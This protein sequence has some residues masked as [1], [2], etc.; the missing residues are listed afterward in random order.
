MSWFNH[1]DVTPDMG[2]R[3]S[4]NAVLDANVRLGDGLVY[5]SNYREVESWELAC[6]KPVILYLGNSTGGYTYQL[7][8][9]VTRDEMTQLVD[10]IECLTEYA[11]LNDT[12]YSAMEYALCEQQLEEIA[13]EREVDSF[14]LISAYFDANYFPETDGMGTSIAITDERLEEL[15]EIAKADGNTWDTHYNSGEFH[16]PEFCTYCEEANRAN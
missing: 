12:R 10:M 8:G 7:T 15:I 13:K 1:Y 9:K 6:L 2:L 11:L 14:L 4:I 16:H 3:Q 5:E